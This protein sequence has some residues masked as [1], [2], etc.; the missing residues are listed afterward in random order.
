VSADTL[1]LQDQIWKPVYG[2]EGRYEVSNYGIVR[3]LLNNRVH[4]LKSFISRHGYYNVQLCKN[5]KMY[6]HKNHRLAAQ[7]FIGYDER[8][9]NHI[10]G[11]KL[12]NHISNLEYVTNRENLNHRLL[13]KTKRL[14]GVHK[15]SKSSLF[16]AVIG[17]NGKIYHLGSFETELEAHQAYLDA[18][19]KTNETKYATGVNQ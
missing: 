16:R 18:L 3:S 10:D 1:S 5:G 6:H 8:Q 15:T 9:V 12:N 14:R 17:I 4:Y 2:Y 19:A 11:D 7:S 13:G